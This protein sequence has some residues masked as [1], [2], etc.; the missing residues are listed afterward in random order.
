VCTRCIHGVPVLPTSC[1]IT[2]FSKKQNTQHKY[3]A[4]NFQY[5]ETQWLIQQGR[6]AVFSNTKFV[7][8]FYSRTVFRMDSSYDSKRKE[9]PLF[10]EVKSKSNAVPLQAWSGPDGS[11][12]FKVPWFRDNGAEWWYVCQPYAP[13]A[14]TPRKYSWY[15]FLLEAESIPGP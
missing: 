3:C 12:R 10:N 13:T 9:W 1:C 14:F 11:R 2:H 7:Y 15:S 6:F 5:F 8:T 4:W